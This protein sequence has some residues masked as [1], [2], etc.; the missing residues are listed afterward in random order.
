MLSA[1]IAVLL[2][3]QTES[4]VYTMLIDSIIL[5]HQHD[6]AAASYQQC[7][8]NRPHIDRLFQ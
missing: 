4:L 1:V 8:D 6:Y 5:F 2:Y 3:R 7:A